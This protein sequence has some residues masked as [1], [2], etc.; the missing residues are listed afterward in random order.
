MKEQPKIPIL[1]VPEMA[2]EAVIEI[3]N[4]EME[5]GTFLL[6]PHA[7]GQETAEFVIHHYD[8]LTDSER[9]ESFDCGTCAAKAFRLMKEIQNETLPCEVV[10]YFVV[11]SDRL[12][13]HQ[14]FELAIFTHNEPITPLGLLTEENAHS[15]HSLQ[16]V[17]DAQPLLNMLSNVKAILTPNVP[18]TP[19]GLLTEENAHSLHSL[20]IVPD[21][22]PL[23]NF[24]VNVKAT[25]TPDVP[26][27]VPPNVPQPS[28]DGP[29]PE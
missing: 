26:I 1:E 14:Q 28:K 17:P 25:L 4:P 19:L 7:P 27:T 2:P 5:T 18:I 29:T 13:A 20:Q 3:E 6:S 22:Q 10:L 9:A 12:R 21:V 8:Y 16:I 23:V 11:H 15:L 24:S